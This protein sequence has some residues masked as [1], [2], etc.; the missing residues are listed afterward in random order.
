MRRELLVLV[1]LTV[2]CSNERRAQHEALA[3][4]LEP[5]VALL[6]KTSQPEAGG[7]D[8]DCA[9]RAAAREGKSARDAAEGLAAIAPFAD[10]ATEGQLA[11]VRKSARALQ[12]A[13]GK[14]CTDAPPP[15]GPATDTVK[16][17]AT[18]RNEVGWNV[19]DL[20]ATLTRFASNAEVHSGVKFPAPTPDG[21]AKLR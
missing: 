5:S 18:A 4:S 19:N 21:C 17:C 8:A 15:D 12:K 9:A 6:C 11:E 13:L 16:A 7:C 14:D 1:V 3:K 10:P 2:A 20:R